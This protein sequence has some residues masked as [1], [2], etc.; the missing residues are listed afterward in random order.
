MGC[1]LFDKDNSLIWI[2][3]IAVIFLLLCGGDLFGPRHC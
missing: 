3:V 2:I 1:N